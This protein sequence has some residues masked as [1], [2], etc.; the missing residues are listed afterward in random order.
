[1]ADTTITGLTAVTAGNLTDAAVIGVDDANLN[2]RKATMAQI[3]TRL[4][5]GLATFTGAVNTGYIA[6]TGYSLTG[7]NATAMVSYA[8]TLNTTG[9]P[10]VFSLAV[11]NTASNAASLLVD[12]LSGAAGA[13]SRFCVRVDGNVG[14]GTTGPGTKLDVNGTFRVGT[15]AIGAGLGILGTTNIGAT[16]VL[17]LQNDDNTDGSSDA[18]FKIQTG[19][20]SGGDPILQ[21]VASGQTNWYMNLDNSDSDKLKIGTSISDS[22]LV[23]QT[24]GNVGIGTATFGTSAV[25]VLGIANGTA[26]S[27][28]PANMGQLYV[29]SGALKYRGSSG[30]IT[31]L[32]NA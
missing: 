31:T 2:T 1:M 3:R 22:K 12:I 5:T 21:L 19:G 28:S 9:T 14:I 17:S 25:T 20:A 24:D 18:R 8:G 4:F 29:E 26:P 6:A 10:T 7:S 15:S 13:T 27:T 23:I 16:N 30:T 11:T 32:G